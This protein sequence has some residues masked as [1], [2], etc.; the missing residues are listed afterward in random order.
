LFGKMSRKKDTRLS[1]ELTISLGKE[2]ISCSKLRHYF[3]YTCGKID[4]TLILL[5]SLFNPMYE[6]GKLEQIRHAKGRTTGS[7]DHTGI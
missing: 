5:F 1:Q 4:L 2:T 6:L 7:K 3:L